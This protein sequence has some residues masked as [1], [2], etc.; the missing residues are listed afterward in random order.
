MKKSTIQIDGHTIPVIRV[1]TA[2][3]GTG[4]AG[5]NAADCLMNLGHTDIAIITDNMLSGT[6]RNTGSDKQTYYKLSLSGDES[7]S[8]AEMAGTLYSGGAMHGDTA[9][10]EAASSARC[11]LKLCELGVPFPTN[12]YGEYAGYKTDHDPRRRATSAGPL[13]SKY[14]TEALEKSVKA[15]GVPILEG[16]LAAKLIV[17]NGAAVGVICLDLSRI[18]ET[19]YGITAVLANTIVWATGGPADCYADIV[20]PPS[21][22]GMS[23]IAFEAGAHGANLHIWQYGLASTK[24]RWNV[25]GSYQQALP[26]YIS[27]DERGTERE[28][29]L[30]TFDDPSEAYNRVFL[31]G[32]EWPWDLRKAR[33]SSMIDVLVHEQTSMGR[34]VYMDYRSNPSGLDIAK[35][36]CEASEYL[37]NCNAHAPTP[38]GRLAQINP[39]SIELYANNGIDLYSEPLEIRVCAQHHNGGIG[40][41]ANWQTN[42]KGLYAVGEAAGTFGKYRPGGSALNSTQ[43][44]SLRAAEHISRS[45]QT[46]TSKALPFEYSVRNLLSKLNTVKSNVS[47]SAAD[48]TAN[49]MSLYAAHIKDVAQMKKMLGE[50]S[51]TLHSFWNTTNVRTNSELPQVLRRYDA[52]LTRQA[53]LSAMICAEVEPEPSDN[54]FIQTSLNKSAYMP[55]RPIPSPERWFE[56]VW[57]EYRK[58]NGI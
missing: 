8:V 48:D 1:S 30:D 47:C 24:F 55:V 19:N 15:K 18:D 32:Y 51:E 50:I 42:I 25:S 58:R 22:H 57:H 26:R 44:G 39:L 56:N 52:L 11:F 23:G 14:M 53:V 34:R 20:Y 38:I 3:V 6:S 13:T 40:C 45:E 41:D 7:D 43:V 49:K 17:S 54:S 27:I 35:L 5:Y 12:E 10:C 37:H 9:L 4:C 2:I 29:L 36:S 31:K 16:F 33:G 46:C 21:Q 28:F